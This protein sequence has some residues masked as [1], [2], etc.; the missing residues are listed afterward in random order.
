MGWEYVEDSL[1]KGIDQPRIVVVG[2]GGGGCNSVNRLNEIGLRSADTIAINTDRPHLSRI[3]AHK[4]LLIGQGITNGMG[5][6]ADPEVGFRCAENAVPEITNLLEGATLVFI[7]VG[8]GGGTG[9][10]LAPVVA[11]VAKR[12]GALVITI[13]TT[14]FEMEGGRGKV[15]IRGIRSLKGVSDTILLMDNNR[16]LEMVANLPV[17]QAFAVMDELISEIIKG[18]TEA[19]TEPSLINLDFADLRT[20]IKKGGISTVLYGENADPDGVVRDALS[21]P[22]LDVDIQGATGAMIHI[23][24]G[25]NLTLKRV[26]KVMNGIN[27]FLDPDA[28]VIIG[29][30]IDDKFE[31]SIRLMAVVTG[32]AELADDSEGLDIDALSRPAIK[33]GT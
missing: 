16:L 17:A 9:T 20:I 19:I 32:I 15:A 5:A 1:G 21:N 3:K 2:C 25:N 14:P 13:A 33:F 28:N 8:L 31:G 6:G 30:R 12:Q 24:G 22:L 18:I 10:G 7:T 27:A 26:S 4:R 29:A 23:T 11:E